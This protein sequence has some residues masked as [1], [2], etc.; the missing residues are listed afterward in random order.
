M[1]HLSGAVC[2]R[3]RLLSNDTEAVLPVASLAW[4]TARMRAS[5]GVAAA[6]ARW[7]FSAAE[8]ANSIMSSICGNTLSLHETHS[9]SQ[10]LAMA[11]ICGN[12]QT[13]SPAF[14]PLGSSARK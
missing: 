3:P 12:N 14:P 11:R 5:P 6:M 7:I 9:A 2:H 1:W 10:R 13:C 8:C 4:R